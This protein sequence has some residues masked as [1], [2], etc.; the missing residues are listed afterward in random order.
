[1]QRADAKRFLKQDFKQ[2]DL[3]NGSFIGVKR[4][5]EQ[6]LFANINNEIV[7]IE[8]RKSRTVEI[9]RACSMYTDDLKCRYYGYMEKK[10]NHDNDIVKIYRIFHNGIIGEHN[11]DEKIQESGSVVLV[12]ER[13]DPKIIT[14]EELERLFGGPVKVV[15]ESVKKIYMEA[16]L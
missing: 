13:K 10:K 12:W 1:M 6:C 8:S 7:V 11:L 4:N 2:C 9:I 14:F 3:E 5:G 16:T 15:H